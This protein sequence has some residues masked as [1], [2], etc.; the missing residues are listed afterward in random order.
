VAGSVAGRGICFSISRRST[1]QSADY[2]TACFD[3]IAQRRL[4]TRLESCSDSYTGWPGC[5]AVS[6]TCA[7]VVNRNGQSGAVQ[8]ASTPTRGASIQTRWQGLDKDIADALTE[9]GET[10]LVIEAVG[11]RIASEAAC[12]RAI[13]R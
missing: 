6:T 13:S 2:P 1:G 3:D 4:E 10:E 7:S 12:W 8:N 9:V 5:R 11:L